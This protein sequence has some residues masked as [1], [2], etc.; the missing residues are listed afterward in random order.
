MKHFFILFILLI[1]HTSNVVALDLANGSVVDLS[2]AYDDKTIYWPTEKGF[3]LTRL[4]Q[5]FTEKGFYYTAHKF[6]S[7]EHGGTHIDAP[8]HFYKNRNTVDQI[9]LKQLMGKAIILDVSKKALKDRDYQITVSDFKSWEDKHGRIPTHTIVLLRTGY[10]KYWPNRVKYMGTNERGAQAVAKLHFPGLHPDA[11]R[12]LVT[13][14]KIKA[15]GL[16]TPSIDY[17]QSK[18]F[19][20]HVILFKNNVPAFENLANLHKLPVTGFSVIA[21]PM[22][23]RGGSGGPLRI[24]GIVDRE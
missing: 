6:Q 21:L 22:K 18:L 24:V 8:I 23:I 1:L 13:K 14:R 11:A 4:F 10:G 15:I 19:Q 3:Q 16:D 17:G 7:P 12:W 20:S 2:Y 5:G 9:P